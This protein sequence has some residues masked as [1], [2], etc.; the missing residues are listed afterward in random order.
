[1]T[2]LCVMGEHESTMINENFESL[3]NFAINIAAS[4]IEFSE[5]VEYLKKNA[6]IN[7]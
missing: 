2:L 7:E 6:I 1:M 5:I 4:K 3:Y